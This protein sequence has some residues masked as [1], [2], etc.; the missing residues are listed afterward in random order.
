[1]T[2]KQHIY[3][4]FA[5]LLALAL[6][7]QAFATGWEPTRR[8]S[9]PDGLSNDFVET[10]T[11]DGDGFVW[12]GTR[13][14]LNRVTSYGV[15]KYSKRSLTLPC[16]FIT[17][18]CHDKAT[19]A[20]IVGTQSG[21]CVIDCATGISTDIGKEQGL[22]QGN[23]ADICTA[24][25]GGVW[26]LYMNNGIQRLDMREKRFMKQDKR[27]NARL[28]R[29]AHCCIDD[30]KGKLYIG[31]NGTGMAVVDYRHGTVT[32]YRHRASDPMSLPSDNVRSI[33]QDKHG[34]IWVG[35]SGGLALF[36][37]RAKKF[38]HM[39]RDTG[40][41]IGDNVYDISVTRQGKVLVSC[42]LDGVSIVDTENAA[43]GLNRINV[44]RIPGSS[45]ATCV[46]A[47]IADNYGNIWVGCY[48]TGVEF[49]N[50]FDTPF[51]NL[52]VGNDQYYT[53][54]IAA[55][56]EG[57]L[58]IGS[59]S[60]IFLYDGDRQVGNWCFRNALNNSSAFATSLYEDS[61]GN[62]WIGFD[63]KGAAVMDTKSHAFRRVELGRRNIDVFGFLELH[64]GSMLIGTEIGIYECRNGKVMFLKGMTAQL[65]SPTVYTMAYDGKGRLWIGT[66]GGGVTVLGKSGKAVAKLSGGH[67]LPS[68]TVTQIIRARDGAMLI[69]TSEGLCRVADIAKPN[70]VV[71]YGAGNG[72]T[73]VNVKAVAEDESGHVWISAYTNIA[74]IDTK[75]G[76]VTSYNYNTDIPAGGY[77]EGA[78][79]VTRD[80]IIYFGSTKGICRID[81]RRACDMPKVSA[82]SIVRCETLDNE[83]QP[84]SPLR[85]DKNGVYRLPYDDSSISVGFCVGNYG[86]RWMVEYSYKMEGLDNKW[87]MADTDK[88]VTFRSLSPGKYKF[89]VRARMLG[90][91]WSD[92]RMASI[93]IVVSPPWWN[94]W[95]M[96][97]IYILMV[98]AVTIGLLKS[99]KHKLKLENS[100]KLRDASLAMERENRKREQDMNESRL[101][102]YTNI[103]HEL[104]TPLTLVIGPLDDLRLANGM[105]QQFKAKLDMAYN[106]A[107]RLL[108]L[109]NRLM[110]F[111]KTETGNHELRVE[112]GNMACV[113]R[114]VGLRFMEMSANKDIKFG[115]DVPK[116][117]VVMLY[118][119]EVVDHIIDNFMSNALK[120][121]PAGGNI[122]LRLTADNDKATISV[123][124]SGYGINPKALLHIFERY[125]QENGK[126]QASGTGIGLAI[127]KALAKLH[128]ATVDVKSE[129]GKGTVFTFSLS[130]TDKYAEAKHIKTYNTNGETQASTARD[131][132][133]T[134]GDSDT[135]KPLLLLADDNDDIRAYVAAELAD[136]YRVAIARNGRE[137]MQMAME[138]TPDIVVSDVM[139][140]E[141]DGI[142]LCGR[143]KND[144][145]TSHVP[146]V[147][148]TAKTTN[149]DREEGYKCGADSYL[150]KPF[151]ANLLRVRLKNILET[152]QRLARMLAKA[153]VDK[154]GDMTEAERNETK[155]SL[156]SMDREFVKQLNK[157]IREN[158]GNSEIDMA[159]FTDRMNMSYS[160]FYRKVKALYDMT[161]VELLRKMRLSLSAQLLRQGDCSVTEA[162]TKSGFDNMGH[163]RKCFKDEYGVA[164]S[165][166]SKHGKR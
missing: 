161:P 106:N 155:D 158:M 138:E 162:A 1:M 73:D 135:S 3:N 126:H 144:I 7:Q 121:T 57:K 8:L 128:K 30:Q 165:E 97:S 27:L 154:A 54:G 9:I 130:R 39:G 156:T 32:N 79:A 159:F 58:W 23:I 33:A 62:L 77:V 122:Q 4:M 146:V 102:F 92:D 84:A 166:Y 68:N 145:H 85:P 49:H 149:D 134:E 82:V 80:G 163:F 66:D 132:M 71:T 114:E 75:S 120:Y 51:E 74:R 142:E 37:R 11:T 101:R 148:L 137:A 103:A 125:Y 152:R 88:V 12:V 119:R 29:T 133:A 129:P 56:R 150:T 28:A 41:D 104:R 143:L 90:G 99:Y 111:R 15:I 46:R 140:P 38:M 64:D 76:K 20:M 127:V 94:T 131:D 52:L 157:L 139:M 50:M 164:P 69:A 59:D 86:E 124:D 36:D 98:M 22:R 48:G 113:V 35:T 78:T 18:L 117:P 136:S 24:R 70:Q 95:W 34:N 63:D 108:N 17:T 123:A 151:S 107:S 100:L 42:N 2:L 109:I 19:D 53:Y 31:Y 14:G 25:D 116:L 60:N 47:A 153:N 81:T 96:D 5:T 43:K 6:S 115:I 89:I 16:D 93:S 13:N 72:L 141:M 44:R 147:L 83:T 105:P 112:S 21:L 91:K 110:E 61:K 67:G 118:D 26:V 45:V 40:Y 65:P 87:Y 55:S 160:S 10:L